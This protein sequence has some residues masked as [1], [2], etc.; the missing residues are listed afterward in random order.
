MKIQ[1]LHSSNFCETQYDTMQSS[2]LQYNAV[3][4]NAVQ[5]RRPSRSFVLISRKIIKFVQ[6]FPFI[7]QFSVPA[8]CEHVQQVA[9]PILLSLVQIGLQKDNPQ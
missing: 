2:A 5:S 7:P 4:Y 3:Q 8:Y 1:H 6:L 9:G